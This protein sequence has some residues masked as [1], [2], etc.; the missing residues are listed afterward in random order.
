MNNCVLFRYIFNIKHG[1]PVGWHKRYEARVHFGL[2]EPVILGPKPGLDRSLLESSNSLSS[3]PLGLTATISL[4][5]SSHR[6]R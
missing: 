3:L 4:L 5:V 1:K 6:Q 2:R